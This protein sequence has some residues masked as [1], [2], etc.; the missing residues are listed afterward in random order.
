MVKIKN[1]PRYDALLKARKERE[2]EELMELDF[3]DINE[4]Y[5]YLVDNSYF[6]NE[7]LRL[8]T[9]INGFNLETLNDCLYARYGYRDLEQLLEGEYWKEG[10]TKPSKKRLDNLYMNM[11]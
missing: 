1:E 8:I 7:E 3:Y 9:D 2:R 10:F 11:V 4:V 5:N 6:T